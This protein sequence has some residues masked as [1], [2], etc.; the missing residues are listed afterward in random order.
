MKIMLVPFNPVVGDIYNNLKRMCKIIQQSAADLA[1]FPELSVCGYPPKDLLDKPS[2]IDDIRQAVSLLAQATAETGI[3]IIV[4]CVDTGIVDGKRQLYNAAAYLSGGKVQRFVHKSLLPTYDVFDEHRYFTP[5]ESVTVLTIRGK[6]FGI[7]ICEDLWFET[8][9]KY[10]V[11]PIEKLI[12]K[13]IDY[14][15]NIS[16]SPFEEGKVEKR[17]NLISSVGKRCGVPLLY[18]NQVGGNDGIIF[19]GGAVVVNGKGEALTQ[20]DR[21]SEEALVYDTD[22]KYTPSTFKFP[23]PD[24]DLIE[25]LTLGI[26]DYTHKTG[27]K[28]VVLGLSGGIDSALTAA[29]AQRALGSEHVKGVSMP[30]RFSSEGSKTDALHLA[31]NLGIECFTI[32][33]EPIFQS[34]LS[35]ISPFFQTDQ[36]DITEENMQARIRGSILMSLSNKHRWLLLT[37][38][39]KSELAVGYCTLYGDMCGG[40]AV[41]ADV[42]KTRVYELAYALNRDREIIP[43][44]S[45]TKPPSAELRHNQTD[46][47]TLPDYGILD[48]ILRLYIEEQQAV[49]DIVTAG[50]DRE[51]VL[52]VVQMVDRTEYKRK[53]AALALKVSVKAFGEG[54]RIPIVQNYIPLDHCP[55]DSL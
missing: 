36:W 42:F 22:E 40:L 10:R 4:G 46:Q 17:L 43:E 50:Y 19:D 7:S 24:D 44:S 48:G 3:D 23:D 14:L 21:F 18:V 27:F 26:R 55:I 41:I 16:A 15:I 5:A 38:G 34:H 37:T 53:Q 52:R 49:E 32:P 25:A 28:T 47:D 51:T 39:N 45:I 6:R 54:R 2:F 33:I 11:D 8:M 12:E 9:R 1:V 31:K 30:S 13:N 35:H 29:L 20:V